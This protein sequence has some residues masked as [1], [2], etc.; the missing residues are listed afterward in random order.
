MVTEVQVIEEVE[1][2][3]QRELELSGPIAPHAQLVRD[4]GL[5]SLGMTVL[6]VGLEDRFRVR[7]NEADGEGIVTVEDLARLVVRRLREQGPQ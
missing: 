2:I 7:L 5:D 1:R 6:A 3:A 4:L